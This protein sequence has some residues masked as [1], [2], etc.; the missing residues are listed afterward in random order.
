M[1][2]IQVHRFVDTVCHQITCRTYVQLFTET[3]LK[4][5]YCNISLSWS[6]VPYSRFRATFASLLGTLKVENL[7]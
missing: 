2:V 3:M 5:E 1:L 6:K 7:M 4:C